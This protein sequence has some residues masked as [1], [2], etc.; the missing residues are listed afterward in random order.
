MCVNGRVQDITA[1]KADL[2]AY[3][4][5]E[6]GARRSDGEDIKILTLSSVQTDDAAPQKR[7]SQSA[8]FL[9]L[10]TLAVQNFER[11][12]RLRTT[13]VLQFTNEVSLIKSRLVSKQQELV[14]TQYD[15][16]QLQLNLQ[17]KA[18]ELRAIKAS[19]PETVPQVL[20][21]LAFLVAC[22]GGPRLAMVLVVMSFFKEKVYMLL[23]LLI[24]SN[25]LR[26]VT[27]INS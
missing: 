12:L 11:S 20:R 16:D 21:V 27:G 15:K 24:N 5:T 4:A 18:E 8:D 22:N 7:W 17:A 10:G 26:T 25:W 6:L 23:K 3:L 13:E 14:A 9:T 19:A 1:K 2:R